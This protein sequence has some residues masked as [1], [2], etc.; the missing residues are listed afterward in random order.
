MGL[1]L[2]LEWMD[3]LSYSYGDAFTFRV[4]LTNDG[5]EAITIPWEPDSERV[6]GMSDSGVQA[7]LLAVDLR[8]RED[9]FS[10]P[11]ATLYGSATTPGTTKTLKPGDTAEVIAAGNWRFVPSPV[12][13]RGARVKGDASISA[14]LSFL[15]DIDGRAYRDLHSANRVRIRLTEP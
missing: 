14:R 6:A 7:A 13:T 5:R 1:R 3:K 11:I 15:T 8:V 9:R 4:S 12:D 10:V 2:R